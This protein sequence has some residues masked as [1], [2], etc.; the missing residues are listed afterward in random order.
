M[1]PNPD[2]KKKIGPALNFIGRPG[3]LEGTVQK[4]IHLHTKIFIRQKF[5]WSKLFIKHAFRHLAAILLMTIR[6]MT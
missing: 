5:R 6:S 4:S 2:R 3:V 1:G